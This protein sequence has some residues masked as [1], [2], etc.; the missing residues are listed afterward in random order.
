MRA[1]NGIGN[2]LVVVG[3]NFLWACVAGMVVWMATYGAAA[4]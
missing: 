1:S 4:L 2:L 3:D